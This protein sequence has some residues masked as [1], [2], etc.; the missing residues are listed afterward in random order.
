L[1]GED[2]GIGSRGLHRCAFVG[3]GDADRLHA[4]GS[5]GLN[6]HVGVFKGE[7]GFRGD[8]ELLR[9]EEEGLGVGLGF[10]VVAGA[11][12]HVELVEE[13]EDAER[14]GDGFARG[15]GDDGEGD[16]RVGFFDLLENFGDGGEFGEE[17]V[18]EALLAER[19]FFDGHGERVAAVERR[20][21]FGN[22]HASPG[23]EEVFGEVGAAAFGEGLFPGDVVERH[24]I[25]DSAIHVEEPG[26]EV[27][28]GEV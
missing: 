10:F 18:V 6:A 13:A 12:H 16:P 5:G 26:A 22:G 9:G 3:L 25:G 17:L 11:D 21:D 28:Y 1:Q 2:W 24:G 19:D 14:G 23:V 27:S 20:D 15:A 4:G 7:A 8:V